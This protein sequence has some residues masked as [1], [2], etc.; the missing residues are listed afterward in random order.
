MIQFIRAFSGLV[1][2][3]A[4]L[5]TTVVMADRS[6]VA[7]PV[8]QYSDSPII[9]Y[10]GDSTVWGYAS[11]TDGARVANPAPDIFA[12]TLSARFQYSVK[13]E[14]VSGSTACS[15]LTGTD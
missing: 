1:F 2:I 13:N 4:S 7:L 12:M 6:P 14:G 3:G 15:L 9:E 5:A 10:Y 8:K 11:G